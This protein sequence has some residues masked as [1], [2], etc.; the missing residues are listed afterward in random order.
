VLEERDKR[1]GVGWLGVADHHPRGDAL[2]SFHPV[3][4]RPPAALCSGRAE[5]SDR[6]RREHVSHAQ[7]TPSGHDRCAVHHIGERPGPLG[8]S[9]I[10]V[11]AHASPTATFPLQPG[12]GVAGAMTT[13]VPSGAVGRRRPG[14][15]H[16]A[17][18][19]HR[20]EGASSNVAR[21]RR[22]R[23]RS[24]LVTASFSRSSVGSLSQ[25]TGAGPRPARRSPRR[26]TGAGVR[27]RRTAV[28][29]VDERA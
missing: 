5:H 27:S 21:R 23:S 17:P 14:G 25:G 4:V 9:G 2:F 10:E 15:W 16:G 8:S 22:R 20:H 19:T 29:R 7:R 12:V 28:V 1:G 11:S 3:S 26:A 18:H 6:H 24:T 13:T